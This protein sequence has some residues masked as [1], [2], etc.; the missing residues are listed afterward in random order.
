MLQVNYVAMTNL[1]LLHTLST[2]AM[3]RKKIM[4][5]VNNKISDE[6]GSIGNVLSDK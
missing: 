5:I 4:K 2:I 1:K 6:T 3:L